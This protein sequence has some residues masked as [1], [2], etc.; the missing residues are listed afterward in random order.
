M[1]GMRD[2]GDQEVGRGI[3]RA[4]EVGYAQVTVLGF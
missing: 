2:V 4:Y 3:K 1:D